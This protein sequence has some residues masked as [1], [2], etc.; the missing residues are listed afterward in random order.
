MEELTGLFPVS[1][2]EDAIMI[3]ARLVI[4]QN[5]SRKC[6]QEI[7]IEEASCINGQY[8]RFGLEVEFVATLAHPF[9]EWSPESLHLVLAVVVAKHRNAQNIVGSETDLF[10]PLRVQQSLGVEPHHLPDEE[11]ICLIG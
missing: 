8:G 4:G 2:P 5:D 9:Q 10:A 6:L 1:G 11:M 7:W 3:R